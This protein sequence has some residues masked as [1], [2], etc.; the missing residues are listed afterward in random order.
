MTYGIDMEAIPAFHDN[1]IWAIRPTGT[2]RVVVVDP[3]DARPVIATL[4]ERGWQLAA[5]LVTHHHWDHVDGIDTL[6]AYRAVPVHGPSSRRIP[7]IDR[8]VADGQHI[9]PLP[10]LELEV[11]AVPGH[12]LDHVAY[13]GAGLA[14]VGDTLF[15]AGCGRLFEGTPDQ[16]LA[17]LQRLAGL[18]DSTRICCAHEY[19]EA[20]LEFARRV[21][22]G[23]GAIVRRLEDV[24]RLRQA[25]RPSLP[26]LLAD[27]RLTN[28]FLR[29]EEADVIAAAEAHAGRRLA[30]PVA[31][32]AELR[33]WKDRF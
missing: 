9:V 12:T 31:V 13:V 15:A 5:I 24:R 25:G 3:G 29:C 19:T 7:S 6:L 2:P 26:S 23:N 21:E 16:M 33:A 27:E 10:G 11:L 32:F 28:P 17:S 1:Y 22:P 30:D 20:N 8:P 18:P 4:E 14:L